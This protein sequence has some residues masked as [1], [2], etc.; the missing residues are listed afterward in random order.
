MIKSSRFG[1]QLLTL[2]PFVVAA[3]ALRAQ[4]EIVAPTPGPQDAIA[5]AAPDAHDDAAAKPPA[6]SDDAARKAEDRAATADAS[7]DRTPR[8]CVSVPDIR[9]TVAIDDYTILFYLRGG[10][11]VYRNYLPRQ[12][13]GLVRENRIAYKTSTTRLC[14]VDLITVLEQFGTGLRPGFTCSLGDFVPITK[15]EAEDLLVAKEDLGRKRRA[16]KS[17]PAELPPAEAAPE[18]APEAARD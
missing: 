9:R 8:D 6:V 13:P 16:I 7:F 1:L 14:D 15:E 5:T 11:R 4:D 3:S 18:S 12:C 10:D 17:K 2:A